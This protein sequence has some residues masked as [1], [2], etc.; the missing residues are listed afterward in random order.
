MQEAAKRAEKVVHYLPPLPYH[1]P[2]V[3][4]LDTPEEFVKLIPVKVF[5]GPLTLRLPD[6]TVH[7]PTRASQA[8]MVQEFGKV[9]G[10]DH[11]L[12]LLVNLV[13]G[14]VQHPQWDVL[15][16]RVLVGPE[17]QSLQGPQGSSKRGTSAVHGVTLRAVDRDHGGMVETRLQPSPCMA[18]HSDRTGGARPPKMPLA[19]FPG[20]NLVI[21]ILG[22]PP[23]LRVCLCLCREHI[24]LDRGYHDLVQGSERRGQVSGKRRTEGQ[25][26]RTQKV[27]CAQARSHQQCDRVK[28]RGRQAE[29]SRSHEPMQCGSQTAIKGD[30]S[31]GHREGR[32]PQDD[33]H[34]DEP[35]GFQN[36][37]APVWAWRPMPVL[38][39][40]CPRLCQSL[41][42]STQLRVDFEL[43]QGQRSEGSLPFTEHLA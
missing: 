34:D 20:L 6:G 42:M 17:H 23:F 9:L 33:R 5:P 32:K 24:L 30:S 39:G 37:A 43:P 25:S 3:D 14:S 2:C 22:V 36:E 26:P 21:V 12:A 8:T 13:E 41:R 29:P 4:L 35:P 38:T 31:H 11:A 19:L 1:F 10:V 15:A 16:E 7:G 28:E 27:A 18:C 40:F